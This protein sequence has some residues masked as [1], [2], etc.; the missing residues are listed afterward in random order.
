M[1]TNDL[2]R[3]IAA[4]MAPDKGILEADESQAT[5]AERFERFAIEPTEESRRRYREMLFTM[6]DVAE[7]VSGVI[8]IDETLGQRADDGRRFVNV[9]VERGITPGIK[10]DLGAKPL[11]GAPGERATEGLAGLRERLKEYRTLGATGGNWRAVIAIGVGQPSGYCLDTNAHALARYAAPCQEAG[12]VPLVEPEVL[13]DGAHS[14]EHAFEGT[15]AALVRAFAALRNQRVLL[16]H[17]LLKPNMVLAGAD[18]PM[19]ANASEVAEATVRRLRR[20]VPVTV[21][22]IVVLSGGQDAKAE[23]DHLNA[24]NATPTS[25]PWPLGFSFARAL[26]EPAASPQSNGMSEA[27]ENTLRRD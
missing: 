27:F 13:M 21:P 23:T 12:L 10:G 16:E 18:S 20:S 1:K 6:P 4:L 9:L 3:P 15:E 11:A 5:I 7:Y 14:I 17:I 8:L 26:Q 24:M 22:G 19:Q 25:L 2:E